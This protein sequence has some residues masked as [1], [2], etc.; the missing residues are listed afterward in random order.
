MAERIIVYSEGHIAQEGSPYD[1]FHKP[2]NP[3][4][5]VLVDNKIILNENI[6]NRSIC[7]KSNHEQLKLHQN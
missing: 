1:I 6:L 4:V 7:H 3:D 5:K 2:V